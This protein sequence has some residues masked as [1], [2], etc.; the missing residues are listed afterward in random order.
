M[1]E[2]KDRMPYYGHYEIP[3]RNFDS[4]SIAPRREKRK[5][6]R[7]RHSFLIVC[8][9]LLCGFAVGFACQ[10]FRSGRT[11][12]PG[13][14]SNVAKEGN[15]GTVSKVTETG[16]SAGVFA[17]G[18]TVQGAEGSRQVTLQRPA[19]TA[20]F[21]SSSEMPDMEDY[22]TSSASYKGPVAQVA[23]ET[24]PSVVA[25]TTVSV[26]EIRDYFGYARTRRYEGSGS[27]ILVGENDEEY[28]IATNNHVIDG[29]EE[30]NVFFYG[31][32][33]DSNITE[34]GFS[35]DE[36]EL[37]E[38]SAVP[39]TIKG[40]DS[41]NDLAVVAVK[42][43]DVPEKTK[44][45]I[46]FVTI[47]DSDG[48]VVGEQVV[49]IGNALGYGQS[50]T[51]G[52][53]SALGRSIETSDGVAKNLIQTD[54]AIN[55]G[56]SGGALL[57]MNGELV[58][59]NS[60]KYADRAVEGMGY[61]I[62]INTAS[63]ILEELMNRRT[64]EKLDAED[65]AYMGISLANISKDMMAMY[66]LP[67]GAFVVEVYPGYAAYNAGIEKGDIIVRMDGQKVTSGEQLISLLQYYAPGETVNMVIARAYYGS[68]Q[69]E[70]VQVT[71]GSR[72]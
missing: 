15:P 45:Q 16:D 12:D 61:A 56:N 54:A 43:S 65:A 44:S 53:I 19:R 8:L 47:G 13:T 57:N 28:L 64:R 60:A 2:E 14:A 29:A 69:E 67:S 72:P 63:P 62:P 48:L 25:I 36:S 33:V 38:G 50:V 26:Q 35:W 1:D 71:M 17:D 30:L 59:I 31:T 11:G 32:E 3:D 34:Y 18:G 46:R 40:T 55:P 6:G 23:A 70:T 42:K 5:K 21:V 51:S 4:G 7:R 68:Y 39:G 58:G 49:A 20:D 37:N 9:A 52:W 66:N 27:G 22:G 41:V 24:M 10:I